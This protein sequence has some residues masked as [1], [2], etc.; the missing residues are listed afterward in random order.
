M[1]YAALKHLHVSCAILSYLMFL[2]RGILMLRLSPVLRQRW[3]KITPHLIDTMLLAS[4][5]ALAYTIR[6]YPFADTWLTAKLFALLLYIALG[7]IALKHGKQRTTRIAAWLGAQA[8]FA[9]I[10][11]VAITHDPVPLPG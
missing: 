7:S 8:A 9:Y 3:I 5:I 4:A 6:Q 2:W 1:G 11:L 10:V